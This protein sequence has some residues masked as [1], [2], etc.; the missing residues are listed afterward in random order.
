MR[1]LIQHFKKIIKHLIL[2]TK[3]RKLCDC[4]FRRIGGIWRA[5]EL[6][7][8]RRITVWTACEGILVSFAGC[9]ITLKLEM[10][11]FY[12]SRVFI[13]VKET[14][15]LWYESIYSNQ[16]YE[17]SKFKSFKTWSELTRL[18]FVDFFFL[19]FK[20]FFISLFSYSEFVVMN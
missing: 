11:S 5:N 4:F 19:V 20:I 12:A 16:V 7:E 17:L 9:R 15:C 14:C 18:I 2:L 1:C 13:G 8:E 3:K 10:F 6:D